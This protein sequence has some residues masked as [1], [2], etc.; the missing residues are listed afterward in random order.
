MSRDEIRAASEVQ[1]DEFNSQHQTRIVW[2]PSFNVVGAYF[3]Q[4]VRSRAI[5]GRTA[6]RI[7]N[8]IDRAKKLVKKGDNERAAERLENAAERVG[9]DDS[10]LAIALRDLAA[11]LVE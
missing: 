5:S 3:D 11:S 8:D 10:A 2:A 9:D 1:L 7:D 6:D 4:A